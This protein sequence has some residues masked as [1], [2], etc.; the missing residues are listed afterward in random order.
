MT[1]SL[2][3]WILML[4]WLVSGGVAA[5]PNL[6][7]GLPNLVLFLLI[8]ILGWHNFGAPIH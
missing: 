7:A 3:F 8:L 5:W 4:I 2:L 6:R 1:I